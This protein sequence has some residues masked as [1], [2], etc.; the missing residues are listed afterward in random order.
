MVEKAPA[1]IPENLLLEINEELVRTGNPEDLLKVVK[2]LAKGIKAM[3]ADMAD[4]INISPE[5]QR[6]TSQPLPA[7]GRYLVWEKESPEPGEPPVKLLYNN[8][9]AVEVLN[10]PGTEDQQGMVELATKAEAEAGTDETRA[11][12]P[13]RVM[14]LMEAKFLPAGTKMAFYQASAPAGWTQDPSVNDRVLRVVSGSG[15]GSGGD[16]TMADLK[17]AGHALTVDEIPGHAHTIGIDWPI[18]AGFYTGGY[19]VV[20]GGGPAATSSVGGDE[21]HD[22]GMD[23]SGDWR[24][25]YIDVIICSKD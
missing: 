6:D 9:G 23:N 10:R 15:G 20:T 2:G 11:M 22:H 25:S 1:P 18:V 5:Y 17:T 14:E 4:A 13:K 16:W 3:Y 19:N 12:T 24:P 21:A 8:G 7:E